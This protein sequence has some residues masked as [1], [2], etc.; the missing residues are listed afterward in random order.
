MGKI[1][2]FHVEIQV[3]R[4]LCAAS[5][6]FVFNL[7]MSLEARTELTAGA[8]EQGMKHTVF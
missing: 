3:N 2:T 7:V 1:L 8:S 6:K 5:L 4:Q